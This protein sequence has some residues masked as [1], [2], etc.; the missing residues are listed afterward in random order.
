MIRVVN[1]QGGK[2]L[3]RFEYTYD[4]NGQIVTETAVQN[5]IVSEKSFTYD[6]EHQLESYTETINGATSA[7]QYGYS[8]TGNRIAVTRGAN[9][10]T[11]AYVYNASGQL[12]TESGGENG[13]CYRDSFLYTLLL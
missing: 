9:N 1:T 8:E 6:G 13:H 11:I 2:K 10:E 5:G 7:T 12:V 3:S 4:A